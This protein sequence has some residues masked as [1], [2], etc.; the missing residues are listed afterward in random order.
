MKKVLILLVFALLSQLTFAQLK[1]GYIDSDAIIKKLPDAQDIQKQLDQFI[2]E[3]NEELGKLNKEFQVAKDDF[4]KRKLIL[5]DEK[6]K[7]A[8]KELEKL[9]REISSFK[10]KKFGVSGEIFKKQE[11]LMKPIH[12]RI[13]TA[14]KE[15]AEEDDYDYIFDR[16]GDILF[17]FA[18]EQYD[19]TTKILDKIQ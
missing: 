15:V 1:I 8:E 10:Q 16:S 12:N 18:K 11:E 3:W 4:E 13:F 7:A 19:L 6:K 9:E 5:T 14:I 2:L 17:L